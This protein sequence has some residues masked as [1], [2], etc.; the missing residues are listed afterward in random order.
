VALAWAIAPAR[1]DVITFSGPQTRLLAGQAVHE[2]S[3]GVFTY[4]ALAGGFFRSAT[5]GNP[6]PDIEAYP[7]APGGGGVLDVVRNDV[8]GGLFT[9]D[10]A[11]IAQFV[12]GI[13][14]PVHFAGYRGGVF[15]GADTFTTSAASGLFTTVSS[16]NLRGVLLD[17]L[18]L[19]LDGNIG[20]PR[21]MSGFWE[22]ADNLT[23][24]PQAAPSAAP[25]P[26]PSTFVLVA[27]GGGA[28]AGWRRWRKSARGQL[29]R[30]G[31]GG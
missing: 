1:A 30:A 31:R 2:D 3:E 29:P 28:L 22:A 7:F 20:D 27:L 19:E 23:L 26:E 15:Q 17:E 10:A 8:T 24:T 4:N 16:A 5:R 12:Y 13:A 25:V 14:M 21:H 9:F 11:D 18:Q 6:A